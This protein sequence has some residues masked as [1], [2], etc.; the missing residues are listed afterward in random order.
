MSDIFDK[1]KRSEIM[2]KICSKNTKPELFVRKLIFSLGYR[3]R[4]YRNDLP[5]KPDIVFV[6][7]KKVI[8]VNGCF[9]H[10]HNCKRASLP[11]TNKKFWENKISKNVERDKINIKK[12][13]DLGWESLTIWQCGLKNKDILIEKINSFLQK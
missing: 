12:L 11:K 9:W 6:G 2:S 7:K 10:G 4:L 1:D 13:H 8:F 3:Y 5:G